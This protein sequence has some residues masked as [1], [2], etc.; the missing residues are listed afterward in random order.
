LFFN[1]KEESKPTTVV[2]VQE[3]KQPP[4]P[5]A[6]TA[7]HTEAKAEAEAPPEVKDDGDGEEEERA[8][9]S[10]VTTLSQADEDIRRLD[11]E[12]ELTEVVG[13]QSL[14]SQE[15]LFNV[16]SSQ[17]SQSQEMME[18]SL[19][20]AQRLGLFTTATQESEEQEPLSPFASQT[21]PQTHTSSS[22]TG[23]HSSEFPKHP[24]QQPQQRQP[25]QQQDKDNA[26]SNH[27]VETTTVSSPEP[28]VNASSIGNNDTPT[29]TTTMTADASN[30]IRDTPVRASECF[31]SLLDAVQVITEREEFN[32]KL[33][34]LTHVASNN[35]NSNSNDTS[36]LIDEHADNYA[37]ADPAATNNNNQDSSSCSSSPAM[38]GRKRTSPKSA[39]ASASGEAFPS[40]KK[41][42]KESVQ[43][44]E[45]E[46]VQ[47][48]E[49]AKRAAA[50]A[51]QTVADP[52][53]AKKLL[54][55]MALVRE[56]PRMAPS[57]WPPRGALVP[58]GF[59]WAH[60]PPL[61]KGECGRL[62][63]VLSM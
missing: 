31:G 19:S 22:T 58:E 9:Y 8:P 20:L 50:L 39:A 30:R 62:V 40:T 24:E 47:A 35:S 34:A 13:S 49:I 11:E 25:Q 51:E 28:K 7:A 32:S 61:E 5:A 1:M 59:F 18:T 44:R 33:Y 16:S 6:T 15:L 46:H 56:N 27:V 10:Q 52:E 41:P 17:P 14:L 45:A 60:Y 12:G 23:D 63:L 36:M 38:S 4:V 2:V 3:E 43:R 21:Q 48:Q 53:M 54:L 37:D 57:T 26:T 29:M 55:S 42:R